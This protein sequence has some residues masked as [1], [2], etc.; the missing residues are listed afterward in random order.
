[1]G[2]SVDSAGVPPAVREAAPD[3]V[4]VVRP[5]TSEGRLV[6]IKDTRTRGYGA[7]LRPQYGGVELVH[8]RIRVK[9]IYIGGCCSHLFWSRARTANPEALE[10]VSPG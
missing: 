5:S 7:G 6:E 4:V 8:E 3:S 9:R 2:L 10:W 1:M